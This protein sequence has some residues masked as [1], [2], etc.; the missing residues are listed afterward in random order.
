MQLHRVITQA[1]RIPQ[2]K[3]RMKLAKFSVI[4]AAVAAATA[5]E[6]PVFAQGTMLEEVVVTARRREE[7]LQEVPVAITAISAEDIE[8]RSIENTEDLNVLLPN[9][10]IRGTGTNGG[11]SG[12]FAIRGIPGVA[13]Y[14]DGVALDGNQGSLENVVEL[15]RIE[16]LRGPQGTYFG[17]NAISGA[18][19]YITQKPADEFGARVKL[20]L[21][22]YNRQDVV[23]NVDVPLSDTV[24]SK[25]TFAQLSRDGFVHST[26]IDEAFGSIDNTIV[27]GM[28]EWLPTDRFTATF[29]AESS[30]QDGNMQPQVLWGVYFGIPGPMTPEQYNAQGI[31]FNDELYSYG[32][33]EQYLNTVDYDPPGFEMNSDFFSVNLSWDI[34]DT[35][36]FRSITATREFDW[37]LWNDLDATQFVMFD[38]WN[39][40]T[41][42]ETTQEFQL[43]GSGDRYTWVVG[44]YHYESDLMDKFQ[45]W[46]RWELTGV[47]AAGPRP[48]NELENVIRT[49]SALFAEFTYDITDKL[50][51]TVGV[52]GRHAGTECAA[53][54]SQYDF[55][56]PCGYD[57]ARRRR[58]AGGGRRFRCDDAASCAAVPMDRQHH[59]VH[60]HSRRVQCGRR[61]STLRSDAA[62]QRHY[63]VYRR[64]AD[65]HRN[66]P[67]IGPS[68]WSSAI[69]CKL[70]R[71]HMG[72]HPDRRGTGTGHDHDD[73]RG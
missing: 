64:D 11:G 25:V 3:D 1:G 7:N 21:G 40:Q 47:G 35:I 15:E 58:A 22:E 31:P 54:G 30:K 73:E 44:L 62:G 72:R 20:S 14:V 49:D 32:K 59:D 43:L 5:S 42:E 61:Q 41:Q 16:V 9:V 8:L 6:T 63:P 19:Q 53:A 51:L 50:E 70:L 71:R 65:E 17:K 60:Q 26:M 68:G 28:L 37:G 27:R 23:A 34:T 55:S 13:R 45:S 48:R 38:R 29:T 18:V 57:T 2:G 56:Q 46:Q 24:R 36:T 66:W 39:Y 10:D 33:R 67:E 69:E 12:N 52:R 4:S